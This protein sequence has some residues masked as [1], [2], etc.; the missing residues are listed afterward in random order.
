MRCHKDDNPKPSIPCHSLLNLNTHNILHRS[1]LHLSFHICLAITLL[2]HGNAL[3]LQL[4]GGPAHSFLPI[5]FRAGT[6]IFV[7]LLGG[8]SLGREKEKVT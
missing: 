7:L 3:Q 4:L 5:F 2:S 8:K 6:F 1:Q